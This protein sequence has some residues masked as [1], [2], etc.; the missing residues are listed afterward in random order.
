[1]S[2]I[3]QT[4]AN[5]SAYGY[6]TLATSGGTSYE[7]I[8]T[9]SGTGSSATIT[10]SS[11]PSTYVALQLRFIGKSTDSATNTQYNYRLRFNGDTGNN[12]ARHVLAGDGATA[13]ATGASSVDSIGP[14]YTPIPNSG[15]GLTNMMGVGII[16]IHDY[17][18]T[19]KNKTVR[20]LGG[21]DSNGTN[22]AIILLG[23]G[24]WYKTPEVITSITITPNTGTYAE[25]S[26]IA[27]YGVK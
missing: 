20:T 8:A 15:S 26:S 23:S 24:L 5:G 11:I 2:P 19:T 9:E 17:A 16:D 3:L 14:S 22:G 7:S 6:R 10:F 1:M 12:Y 18:S 27:L 21:Y 13:V 25:F 4:L